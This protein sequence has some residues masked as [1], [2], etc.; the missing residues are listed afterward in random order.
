M[1]PLK[2][3][4]IRVIP[5]AHLARITTLGLTSAR[6]QSS[7]TNEVVT[8]NQESES[9]IKAELNSK[10]FSKKAQ[11]GRSNRQ[12]S[13]RRPQTNFKLKDISKQILASVESD[14]SVSENLEILEEGLSYLREIQAAEG[15]TNDSFYLSFQPI[16]GKLLKKALNDTSSLG[17]TTIE[18]ILDVFIKYEVAHEY[19]F[20]KTIVHRLSQIHETNSIEIFGD[21]LKIWV[22]DIEYTKNLDHTLKH[23]SVHFMREENFRYFDIKNLVYFSYVMS[24]LKSNVEYSFKDALKILQ[25]NDVPT[26]FQVK[27]SISSNEL[28]LKKEYNEFA[29]NIEALNMKSLDPNGFYVISKLNEAVKFRNVEMLNQLYK[30]VQEASISNKIPIKETTL[31][32]LMQ[33]YLSLYLF[34]NVFK[35]FQDILTGSKKGPSINSWDIVVRCM[36]HPSYISRLGKSKYEMIATKLG[37]TVETVLSNGIEMTPKLLSSIVGAFYNLDQGEKAEEYLAKYKDLPV[38]QY[39][40]NST[41]VGLIVNGRITEAEKRF[42]EM[43]TDDSNYVPS[44]PVVNAFLGAYAKANNYKAIDGIVAYMKANNIHEDFSTYTTLLDSNFKL[45]RS[46]GLVPD[47]ASLLKDIVKDEKFFTN[48]YS[49]SAL[50]TGLARDGVN[51]EAARSIYEFFCK[52]SPQISNTPHILTSLARAEFDHGSISRGQELFDRLLKAE[53]S[54]KIWNIAINSL[55]RKDDELSLEYYNKLKHQTSKNPN[56]VP[57]NFTYYFLLTHF[58][59]RNNTEKVQYIIDDISK[60]N[61]ENFG[62][63]LPGILNNL[64]ST[65]KFSESFLNKLRQISRD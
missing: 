42:Q 12:E 51:L 44:T 41:L 15:I 9:K 61:M 36:G 45:Y 38:I 16:V 31:N 48:Q 8:E 35:I 14:E 49:M 7:S 60:S 55:L 27:Q 6:F 30:N 10:D 23:R 33:G 2:N 46:K 17:D 4:A 54:T 25:V 26:I 50:I 34:D 64:T 22:K 28:D 63:E 21:V 29:A 43:I 52:I 37:Q 3:A 59:K 47:T 11:P 20:T 24:C 56:V 5:R 18:N 58:I 53:N 65:Y 19:H 1:I 40:K 13:Q 57:N 32:N 62:T 39:T